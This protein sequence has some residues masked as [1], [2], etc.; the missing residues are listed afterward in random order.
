MKSWRDRAKPIIERVLRE[1]AGQDEA[2]IR[3]A[4]R[5]AYPFGQR[6]YHPYKVWLDEIARQRGTRMVKARKGTPKR[7]QQ[8]AAERTLSLF[9]GGA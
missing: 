3:A 1:T 9:G 6:Q 2:L 7:A 5:A 8:E 4:L